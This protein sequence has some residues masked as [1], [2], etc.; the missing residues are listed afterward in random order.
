M[1]LEDQVRLSFYKDIASVDKR[2]GVVLVQHTDTGKVYVKK[3]L[4]RYDLRVYDALREGRYPGIPVINE[5]IE[6]DDSLIVIEDYISGQSI[7]ELIESAA[8]DTEKAIRVVSGLCDILA[9]LHSHEPPIIHR[10]IKGANVIL[11]NES[12][13]YLIDFDASKVVTKGRSHDTD[14]IGTEEYAA[15]EQYGF[16]QSDQRTDIYALGILLQ[17]MLDRSS[18]TGEVR[19]SGLVRIVSR[20]TELDPDNRYRNVQQ[21]KTALEMHCHNAVRPRKSQ[22]LS[23]SRLSWGS[24]ASWES[25]T[26]W[27]SK[28]FYLIRALPGL[29]S[30]KIKYALPAT[31]WYLFLLLFGFFGVAPNPDF[32]NVQNKFYDFA[33]FAVLFVPTL[34]L[35]NYL[36][37]RN[38][39]PWQRSENMVLEILRIT[40]G[41]AFSVLSVIFSV[42]IISMILN[43]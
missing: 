21:L 39:L 17:K 25:Q 12:K 2:H 4:K 8:I 22:P 32:T 28:V 6:T 19:D 35:G 9:P 38:K 23:R 29:R 31:V 13:V 16:R 10:D 18:Q 27:S 14:L 11:D 33:T 26:S 41:T 3:T 42:S 1:E 40:A 7:D 43:I 30:G 37:V 36:G 15:P 20:A 24:Q 5:M 34:Y